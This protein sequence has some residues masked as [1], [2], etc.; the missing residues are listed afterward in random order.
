M[1]KILL[2]SLAFLI[3]SSNILFAQTKEFI[4]V[5][6]AA[7]GDI[8]NQKDE[9]LENGSKVYYGDTIVVSEK[10]NAQVL[11]LDQTVITIGEKS[12]LKIDEFVYDPETNDGKF[13]SNIKSGTIKI[14]TGEISKKDPDNLE[15]KIPTGTIGARGTEF[16]VLTESNNESTVVLLGPGPNNSLGMIPGNLEVSDGFNSIDIT[17]PGFQT[18]VTN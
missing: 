15:I 2:S 14:I 8:K 3:L 18:V 13:V 10:S 5:I 11:F 16:V 1:K 6:G 9:I 4:G 12:E 17:Q 7:I